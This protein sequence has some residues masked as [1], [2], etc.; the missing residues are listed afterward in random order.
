MAQLSAFGCYMNGN[1]V[2]VPPDFG[3]FGTASR[4]LFNEAPFRTW[5]F[6]ILNELESQRAD[7][8]TIPGAEFFNVLNHPVFGS[9]DAG[10]LANND[11]SVGS[12]TFGAANETADQAAGD[13]VLGSGANRVIQLGLKLTF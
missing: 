11:P 12:N 3:T 10:H 4:N 1:S 8:R 5:D 7:D 2:L 6:S 9:V 13:P